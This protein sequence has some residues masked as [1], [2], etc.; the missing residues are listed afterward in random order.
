MMATLV[1][2]VPGVVLASAPTGAGVVV[3][4]ATLG[5]LVRYA[6]L[7]DWAK[8][9]VFGLVWGSSCTAPPS[10][11]QSLLAAASPSP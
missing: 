6:N 11:R 9:L 5:E 4:A 8:W 7:G 10:P 1:A 3:E 2:S